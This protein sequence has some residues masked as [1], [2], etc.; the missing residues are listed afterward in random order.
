LRAA[1][2]ALLA[3]NPAATVLLGQRN[4][5]Q[6]EAAAKIGDA[7]TKEDAGWVRGVYRGVK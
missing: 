2:G 6:V 5:K 1:T 3:G 7:L 4:V